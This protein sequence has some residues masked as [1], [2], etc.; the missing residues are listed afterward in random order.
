MAKTTVIT[1][2]F[3]EIIK[4]FND[5]SDQSLSICSKALYEGAGLMAD[6]LKEEIN[7]LPVTDQRHKRTKSLLPY[8]KEALVKG[9][10]IDE[11]EKDSARDRVSTKITFHGYSDHPTEEYPNGV[12]IILLARSITAG[13]TFRVANR[14]F[15]NTVRRNTTVVERKIQEMID[16][17]VK[18][19]MK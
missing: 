7:S 14:F 19:I 12:P 8:E 11:F 16:Q 9:L 3:N 4:E 1:T 13:T 5:L 18:K 17:E 15:P 2:G 10:S 6:R